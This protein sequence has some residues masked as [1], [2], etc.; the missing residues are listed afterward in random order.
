[1]AMLGHL[2]RKDSEAAS[3]PA[4]VSGSFPTVPAS[5]CLI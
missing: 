3:A 1:M 4:V 2:L 5:A